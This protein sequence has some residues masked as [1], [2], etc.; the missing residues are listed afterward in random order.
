M[1]VDFRANA[2]ASS[3]HSSVSSGSCL[4]SLLMAVAT[5]CP[6]DDEV[7]VDV[8]DVDV[9][10]E[11]G[12]SSSVFIVAGSRLSRGG[13]SLLV[14]GVLVSSWV[15]AAG[16]RDASPVFGLRVTF[17]FEFSGFLAFDFAFTTGIFDC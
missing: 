5:V 13:S 17:G 3:P 11:L 7:D 6:E 16:G 14:C 15:S 2:L 9:V 1:S 12:V 4:M 8:V 10:D